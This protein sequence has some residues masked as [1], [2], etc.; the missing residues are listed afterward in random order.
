M[1]EAFEAKPH[2]GRAR[3][4]RGGAA[5]A[6]RAR[7][8]EGEERG[9]REVAGMSEGAH[10]SPHCTHCRA[11]RQLSLW[12][13]IRHSPARDGWRARESRHACTRPTRGG[14]A[15]RSADGMGWWVASAEKRQLLNP[16]KRGN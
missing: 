12:G 9:G 4:R 2:Q 14:L 13:Q 3:Q 6:L 16:N 7:G 1:H 5:A 15:S 8:G 10:P 11:T